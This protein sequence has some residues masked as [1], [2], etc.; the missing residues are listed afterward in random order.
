MLSPANKFLMLSVIPNVI[1]LSFVWLS[2]AA[3][4]SG[5]PLLSKICKNL[6][7][8]KLLQFVTDTEKM[9]ESKF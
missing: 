4:L 9:S 3:P 1:M 7:Y 8:I 2:V 5:K 6:G